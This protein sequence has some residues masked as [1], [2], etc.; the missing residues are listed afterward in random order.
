RTTAWAR[1]THTPMPAI[2]AL[3]D[4]GFLVLGKAVG[5]RVL[6]QAPTSPRLEMMNKAD[7]EAIWDGRIVMMNRRA[8]LSDL[9]SRFDITWFLG[10][11]HKYRKLLAEVLVASFFLQLFAL[12]TPLFFQVV[13][14]KVLVHQVLST[15]NVLVIG[16]VAVCVFQTILGILRTHVF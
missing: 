7:L 15:L 2:A 16:L 11:I 5:D 1:L 13:I 3:R 9:A 10:A 8:G 4:G 14:D 6:V 12:V